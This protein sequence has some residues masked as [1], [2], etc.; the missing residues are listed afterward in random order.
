[1]LGDTKPKMETILML[2]EKLG[3]DIFTACDY[4]ILA[5][6]DKEFLDIMRLWPELNQEQKNMSLDF[7]KQLVSR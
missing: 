4:P 6:T 3:P 5:Y 7:I 1:M 2:S